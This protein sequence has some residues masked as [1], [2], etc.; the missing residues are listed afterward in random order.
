M[1]MAKYTFFA[2]AGIS[3]DSPSKIPCAIPIMKSIINS[4]T[5]DDN[6]RNE[7]M[8]RDTRAGIDGLYKSS[9]DYLRFEKLI[10]VVSSVD[11]EL[12]ILDAIKNY[13]SPN[14][15]HYNLAQLAIDGNFVF[16][17]NFDDLIERAIIEMG[18]VPRT[19][20]SKKDYDNFSFD[21]RNS[22]PVFK[23]HGSY[24][25]YIGRGKEKRNAKESIQ[26]TIRSI[27]SNKST[28]LLD[29]FKSSLIEKCVKKTKKLIF[30][31]YSGSDDFDIVPSLLQMTLSN[32]LWINHCDQFIYEN[33][34]DK[35]LE[36]ESGR[37]KLLRM[38]N[39][40]PGSHVE[41]YDI[42]TCYFLSNI[43][44]IKN[45][46]I[47][48]TIPIK[49]TFESHIVNWSKELTEDEKL[50]VIG[51]LFRELGFYKR[52]ISFFERIP[53]LSKLFVESR[54]CIHDCLCYMSNYSAALSLLESLK[55]ING[56]M[57]T[58][59]YVDLLE[60]EAYV[61]YRIN[62]NDCKSESLFKEVLNK[63]QKNS[64]L[65]GSA[66]NNYG[67][68][69]RDNGRVKEA[70]YFFKKGYNYSV[71]HGDIDNA[72]LN[73]IN[74]SNILFDQGDINNAELWALKNLK[75]ADLLGDHRQ[76]SLV[77]NQLANISYIRGEYNIAIQYCKSS[78]ERDVYLDNKSDSYVNEMLIGQCYFELKDFKKAKEHY[79]ESERLIRMADDKFFQYELYFHEIVLYIKIG[80]YGK[81]KGIIEKWSGSVSNTN[82][83]E[84]AYY[85]IAEKIMAYIMTGEKQSFVNE[86]NLFVKNAEVKEIIGFAIVVWNLRNLGVPIANIGKKNI[87]QAAKFYKKIGNNEKYSFFIDESGSQ[88][89]RYL[90][91]AKSVEITEAYDN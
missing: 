76:I 85:R 50:I 11:K 71:K 47:K 89:N 81:A 91:H 31:G 55:Q 69:L 41:L 79:Q 77:E 82:I 29:P 28:L 65:R 33:V 3:M 72:C 45:D 4:L 16:T 34:V 74:L 88:R 80:K 57:E 44:N 6:V 25:R 15:N 48:K 21:E 73:S 66:M 67:L 32:I 75:Q 90:S 87:T 17:T 54:L 61:R 59:E 62:Y 46:D 83:I 84:M 63:A 40:E 26:A 68:F 18:Q 43:G 8:K 52:A 5:T 24:Y 49:T 2:G 12:H 58:R 38:F 1:V 86:I 20:C 53:C 7:L 36:G 9:G 30:V 42:K 27:V 51:R 64:A 39:K 10:E 23:L 56:I 70:S 19:I 37:S 78:I 13:K 22:I 14:L 60:G 35:Y